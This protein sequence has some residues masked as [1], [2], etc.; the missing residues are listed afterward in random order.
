[1]LRINPCLDGINGLNSVEEI[2]NSSDT[3]KKCDEIYFSILIPK[4]RLLWIKNLFS[5]Y[6]SSDVDNCFSIVGY[7]A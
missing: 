3:L 2:C 5:S 1:M 6:F 4:K 7:T